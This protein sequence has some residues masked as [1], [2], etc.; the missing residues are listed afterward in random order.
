[1]VVTI[2]SIVVDDY[3]ESEMNRHGVS[4]REV[5]QVL[6]GEFELLRNAGGH[7]ATYLMVGKTRGGR[8]LTIPIAP[9]PQAGVWRPATAFPARRADRARLKKGGQG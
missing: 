8:W 7:E 1:M 4:V 3:N 9:T 6:E 5:F 2:D